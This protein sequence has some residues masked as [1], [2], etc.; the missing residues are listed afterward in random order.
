M[1]SIAAHL[2]YLPL[3][4]WTDL[5]SWLAML[6]FHHPGPLCFWVDFLL[7]CS[8]TESW[9]P[10]PASW[11]LSS[12]TFSSQEQEQPSQIFWWNTA[13]PSCSAE[14]EQTFRL[15]KKTPGFDISPWC[16][17]WVIHSITLIANCWLPIHRDIQWFISF[18]TSTTI[19]VMYY[20]DPRA[21]FKRFIFPFILIAIPHIFFFAKSRKKKSCDK[22]KANNL[23]L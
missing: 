10:L 16:K 5:P 17:F 19:H 4:F 11:V 2:I 13:F 6:N 22:L 15:G 1:S 14:S 20:K 23:M 12:D 7:I 18:I 9:S 8:R 3:K 21:V